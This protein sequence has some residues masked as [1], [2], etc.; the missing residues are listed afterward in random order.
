MID[1]VVNAVILILYFC[2]PTQLIHT[3]LNCDELKLCSATTSQSWDHVQ[4]VLVQEVGANNMAAIAKIADWIGKYDTS[5][6]ASIV[7]FFQ[8]NQ[9]AFGNLPDQILSAVQ[10]K[11][12]AGL[13]EAVV[14]P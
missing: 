8:D 14:Q 1:A 11:L 10:T 9:A 7:Q 5:N 6:P 4:S 2:Q 12:Q 3:R 13:A